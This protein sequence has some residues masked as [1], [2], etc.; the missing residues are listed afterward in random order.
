MEVNERDLLELRLAEQA[1]YRQS[2]EDKDARLRELETEA[3]YLRRLLNEMLAVP[4][5]QPQPLPQAVPARAGG[6]V[7]R[8][9][10]A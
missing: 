5:P 3:R 6:D 8:R 2:L 4:R 1:L 9:W 7:P 10:R